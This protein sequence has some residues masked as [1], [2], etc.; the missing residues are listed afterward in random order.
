MA[1]I[2]APKHKNKF[3]KSSLMARL[4]RNCEQKS[5]MPLPSLCESPKNPEGNL[6][7]LYTKNI[8]DISRVENKF[9]LEI[10]TEFNGKIETQ[11]LAVPFRTSLDGF[12]KT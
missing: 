6:A 2:D 7:Y 9:P 4:I 8:N 10:E 5:S 1:D 3:L 11:S 12:S